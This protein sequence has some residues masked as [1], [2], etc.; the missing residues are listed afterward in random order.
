MQREL[1]L[2]KLNSQLFLLRLS[3]FFMLT[4]KAKRHTE[5]N[6][7]SISVTLLP[8]HTNSTATH[9]DSG[10]HNITTLQGIDSLSFAKTD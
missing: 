5:A 1:L 3:T 7:T 8:K 10:D 9:I 4:H 6:E 2:F